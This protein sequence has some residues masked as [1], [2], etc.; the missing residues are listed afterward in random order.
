MDGRPASGQALVL[1]DSASV[2]TGPTSNGQRGGGAVGADWAGGGP[3]RAG[4]VTHLGR[5]KPPPLPVTVYKKA[6]NVHTLTHTLEEL[7]EQLFGI[8]AKVS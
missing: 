4:K 1:V 3:G 7:N 2:P 5:A 6:G 8:N